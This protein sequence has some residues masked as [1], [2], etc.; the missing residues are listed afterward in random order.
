VIAGVKTTILAAMTRTPASTREYPRY[1]E[2]SRD[3]IALALPSADASFADAAV[4]DLACGTGVTTC[5]ILAVLGQ[6]GRVTGVNKSAAMLEVAASS[7]TDARA[8]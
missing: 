2:T 7:T 4:V 3:L 6:D 5:E 8:T 1:R